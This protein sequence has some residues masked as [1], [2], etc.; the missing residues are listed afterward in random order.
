MLSERSWSCKILLALKNK[1]RNGEF[2]AKVC[3]SDGLGL[4]DEA[5][6]A[7]H[8]TLSGVIH[9]LHGI[10]RSYEREADGPI[11]KLICALKGIR[12]LVLHA[13]SIAGFVRRGRP[14][15]ANSSMA[16]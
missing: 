16:R 5:I 14:T 1:Y 15:R 7:Q 8:L 2:R 3:G 13:A 6:G 4:R 12:P 11:Q 9:I 10:A